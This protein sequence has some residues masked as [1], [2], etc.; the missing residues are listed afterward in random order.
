MTHFDQTIA[1]V[2]E[3]RRDM[4]EM[5][6]EA[7]AAAREMCFRK[8]R[9]GEEGWGFTVAELAAKEK[10][11]EWK[12]VLE[13]RWAEGQRIKLERELAG[14]LHPLVAQRGLMTIYSDVE[15]MR[16]LILRGW[17]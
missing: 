11:R 8:E 13:G 17:V 4:L 7:K 3:H 12:R 1:E 14:E 10:A 6:V 16:D 15:A 5:E 2:K 9:E